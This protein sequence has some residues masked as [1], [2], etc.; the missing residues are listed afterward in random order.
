MISMGH[1][2]LPQFSLSS[3]F[4]ISIRVIY[5]QLGIIITIILRLAFENEEKLN[6]YFHL[7]GGNFAPTLHAFHSRFFFASESSISLGL[8]QLISDTCVSIK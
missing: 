1:F 6:T 2:P 3:S 4:G 8:L 7:P 5:H